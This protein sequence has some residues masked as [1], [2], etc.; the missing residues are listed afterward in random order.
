MPLCELEETVSVVLRTVELPKDDSIPVVGSVETSEELGTDGFK[1]VEDARFVEILDRVLSMLVGRT[2]LIEDVG[3]I[4]DVKS[5]ELVITLLD[6]PV[7]TTEVLSTT[8]LLLNIV[9]EAS[10]VCD[11]VGSVVL[12][13]L[14]GSDVSILLLLMIEL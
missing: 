11:V 7:S 13:S 5:S 2:L 14:L 8:V 6:N 1:V 9:E 4:V 12:T 3:K 10:E